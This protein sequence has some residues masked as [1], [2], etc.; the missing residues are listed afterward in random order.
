M[1]NIESNQDSGLELLK[2]VIETNE[3]NTEQAVNVVFLYEDLL[4]LIGETESSL[5]SLIFANQE[6]LES[7]EKEQQKRQEFLEQIPKT[8]EVK[9]SEDSLQQLNVFKRKSKGIKYLVFG[10]VGML[11]L[12]AI[13]L[14]ITSVLAKDWY[15][16]SIKTKTELRAEIFNEIEREGKT[17]Y[18]TTDLEKLKDNTLLMQKWMQKSPKDSESFLRFKEGYEASNE[19]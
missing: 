10:S 12:S 3:R 1:E 14:F 9:F 19:R 18:K 5:R 7:Q 2:K 11:L 8:L 13:M 4:N 15:S 16:K 6:L 17:I